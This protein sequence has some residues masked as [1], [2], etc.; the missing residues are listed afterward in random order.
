MS[1]YPFDWSGKWA[2]YSPHKTALYDVDLDIQIH[3]GL[4]DQKAQGIAAFLQ[5]ELGIQKGDRIAVLATFSI[6][7]FALFFAA[8][9]L[10]C[11]LV[12]L[13]YRLS[14]REI[15]FLLQDSESS[16]LF[17]DPNFRA[18]IPEEYLEKKFCEPLETLL[19]KKTKLFKNNEITESDPIFL[20]YTSGTTGVP[21]GAIYTH[22]M[23][24]WNSLNT[25]LRLKINADDSTLMVMP[26]FHTGGWNVLSTPLLHFGATVYFMRKFEAASVL[27][28]LQDHQIKLFMAV[29]T[30]VK[31]LAEQNTF[32][33]AHFPR[34]RYFI[35]GGEALP[36]PLIEIWA[37][38]G[39]PIRQGYGLTEAGPNITSLPEEDAIRKRGSVGF[40]NFY[41]DYKI[42]DELGKDLPPGKQGELWLKGPMLTPGYWHNQAA[43]QSSFEQGWFK[44]GDIFLQDQEGYLYVVDR[45]KNMYISG[46]ENV[47]PTEIEKY[48]QSHPA[49]DEAAVIAI[50]DEKWGESGK[51]FLVAAP[52]ALLDKKAVFDYC[53]RGLAKFKIP[54]EIEF[55]SELPKTDTGKIDK[56]KLK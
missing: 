10:G 4:L 52:Q 29:P 9:K 39:V 38:K 47:Y 32:E 30:M 34:L 35:V 55:L 50:P 15:H 49:I 23:M 26:P 37:T 16:V 6:P 3:Y 43:N 36:I 18:L 44:T 7:Y 22:G 13:N 24:L 20:L 8:Q 48:L 11:I 5:E 19:N 56:K 2:Q 46:G 33:K 14:Q 27:Q 28:H 21:K 25:V 12:P 1:T 42:V 54:K 41:V 45:I 31:M 51:A 53:Q 40:M 17:Y